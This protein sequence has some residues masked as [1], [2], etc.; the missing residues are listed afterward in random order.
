MKEG[1][2]HNKLAFRLMALEFGLRDWLR[3]PGRI[4]T[5]A[6]IRT[7][8]AV[9]DF[10]CGP[11]GF[12]VAAARLVGPEGRVYALD[13]NPFAVQ[14]VKKAAERGGLGNLKAMLAG[15]AGDVPEGSVDIVLLYD[16]LHDLNEPELILGDIHRVLRAGGLLSVSDHHLK[17]EQLQAR[18]TGR[19]LFKYA[20]AKKQ[21]FQFEK[22]QP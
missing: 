11:G 8:Q 12:S 19:G 20:G 10:G 6:G 16:T 1:H 17:P 9:L 21:V 2:A 4:L 3:P 5:E 15:R 13:I 22:T 14:S 7:G 18:V